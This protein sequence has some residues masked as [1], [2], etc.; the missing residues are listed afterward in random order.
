MTE[1]QHAGEPHEPDE[2]ADQANTAPPKVIPADDLF[3]DAREV[4]I[5]FHG[6]RYRLRITRRNK[7]I[8]QK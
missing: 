5:D 2:Q 1:E 4:W 6:E 7:L 8:L 3:G